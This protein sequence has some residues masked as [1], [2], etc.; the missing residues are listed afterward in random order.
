M[1]LGEIL[2]TKGTE[3]VTIDP[4]RTVLEAVRTLVDYNIGALVVVE[5][6][7]PVGI[8]SERDVLRLTSRV[9]GR[10][11]MTRVAEVMTRD[12]VYASEDTDVPS[13]METMTLHRIRHLPLMRNQRLA[14]IVSI[15]DVVNAL[16]SEFETENQH[17]KRYIYRGG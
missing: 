3:V 13:A 2:R 6:G 8:L 1:R 4:D 17:L 12:V 5:E 16:R 11:E 7:R 10:L 9:P 14:G 15:G